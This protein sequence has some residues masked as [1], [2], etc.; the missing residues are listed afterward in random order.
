MPWRDVL[1]GSFDKGTSLTLLL[2]L[3]IG[4]VSKQKPTTA[5]S[6]ASEFWRELPSSL[7]PHARDIIKEFQN[8]GAGKN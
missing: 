3:D 7:P 2:R 4:M 5:N 8:T 1:E 6:E